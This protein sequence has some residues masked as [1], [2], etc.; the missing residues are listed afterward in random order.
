MASDLSVFNTKGHGSALKRQELPP[1][2]ALALDHMQRICAS[3]FELTIAAGGA[4]SSFETEQLVFGACLSLI[5]EG[6][7]WEVA[8]FGDEAG[9]SGLAKVIF[10]MEGNQEPMPDEIVDAMGELIN[11]VSGAVKTRLD[12]QEHERLTIGVPIFHTSRSDCEKYRTKVIPLVSQRLVSSQIEGVLY[13][14]W[15]ERTPIVLLQEARVCIDSPVDKLDLGSGLAVLHELGEIVADFTAKENVAAIA[16][17]QRLVTDIINECGKSSAK[18]VVQV[19]DA[20]IEALTEDPLLP[21][22]M[23]SG[24]ALLPDGD[25]DESEPQSTVVRDAETLEMLGEFLGESQEGL[26]QCDQILLQIEQGQGSADSVAALFRQFHTIKGIASFHELSDVEHLAHSTENLLATVRDGKRAFEGAA[27]DL[28]FEST[29]LMSRQML[30][31]REAVE[32]SLSFPTSKLAR[33][34]REK[35]EALLRG[36]VVDTTGFGRSANPEEGGPPVD[37]VPKAAIKETVKVDI[38][39]LNEFDALLPKFDHIL[40]LLVTTTERETADQQVREQ[41]V[42]LRRQT[43]FLSAKMRMVPLRGLFQKMTRMVRDLSKKT[44][45][46]ARLVLEG[47]DTRVERNIAEKLN[48]PL[49]HMLRNAID[50]GLECADDR[51]LTGKPLIGAIRL[52]ARQEDDR[53]VI[54]IADDGKGLDSD[55]IWEKALSRGLIAGPERPADGV[56]FKLIFEAGFSTAAKVTAISGRGVGM[57]VVRREIE[58]LGGIIDID[59]VKGAGS[60]FRIKLPHAT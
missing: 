53:I 5:G 36:E 33:V 8:L 11:M 6:G 39:L 30:R 45:K 58:T 56:L 15:S 47:E 16:L 55:A 24:D 48:G 38:E 52:A 27:V 29:S 22:Q 43:E 3:M 17:C 46:L 25:D 59:S 44:E 32:G 42:E 23:P 10:A 7:S 13:L 50:H 49:V 2:A 20:L 31:I 1:R 19:I 28:V 40:G 34:L 18:F 9:C 21:L 57:D 54:E 51:R 41:I 26:E 37:A 60:R 12:Q 14:V 4:P 35:I